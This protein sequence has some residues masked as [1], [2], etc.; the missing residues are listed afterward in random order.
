MRKA[1]KLFSIFL[2]LAVLVCYTPISAFAAPEAASETGVTETA[3]QSQFADMPNDWSTASLNAAVTNGLLKGYTENGGT[4]I[5]P[6]GTLTRAELTAVV[7]RAFGATGE[8]SLSGV[9]DVP[10]NA[11]Y[12]SDIAKA[13]KMG[14]LKLDT[15][16]RPD[17]KITRQETGTILARAFKLN[18]G[19]SSALSKFSDGSEVASWAVDG[20]SAMVAAGYLTGSDSG[21]LNPTANIT[22]AEFS[23]I[24]DNMVGKYVNTAGTVTTSVGAG[25]VMVNTPGATLDGVTISGN[26][27]IGE[28]VGDGNVTLNNVTVTGDTIV[29]GGGLNSFIVK[30]NSKLGKIIVSKADGNVRVSVEGDAN[31]G[32]VY[33]NDGKDDVVIEGKIGTVEV[34]AADVPV[35]VQNAVVGTI[36]VTAANSNLDVAKTA[37]V[38]NVNVSK[39][40]DGASVAVAG[41]VNKLTTDAP[42][43]EIAVSGTVTTVQ[44]GASAT[45][46]TVDVSKDGKLSSLNSSADIK[47]S[48]EGKPGSISGSGTVTDSKGETT[49]P[50]ATGGGGGGGGGGNSGNKPVDTTISVSNVAVSSSGISLKLT[51]EQPNMSGS[52]IIPDSVDY[53]YDIIFTVTGSTGNVAATITKPG[54]FTTSITLPGIIAGKITFSDELSPSD[55]PGNYVYSVTVNGS[56]KSTLTLTAQTAAEALTAA[57]E[58]KKAGADAV[59]D[60]KTKN[61]YTAESWKTVT[62]AIAADKVEIEKLTTIDTVNGYT[63]TALSTDLILKVDADDTLVASKSN[64]NTFLQTNYA[65]KTAAEDA[66][67]A[68]ATNG[69][70]GDN[71]I[72][73]GTGAS[74]MTAT[75]TKN[76]GTTIKFE[77]TSI[78]E[79]L[80]ADITAAKETVEGVTFNPVA[81][82]DVNTSTLA[83][84][85]VE[86]ILTDLELNDVTYSVSEKSFV[87]AIAG[88]SGATSGTNGSYK[89]AVGLT[90]GG[91]TEQTT[92]ELTLVI[93][94]TPYSMTPT[95]GTLEVTAEDSIGDSDS[96]VINVTE[97]L[98]SL[99]TRLYKNFGSMQATLPAYDNIIQADNNGWLAFPSGGKIAANNND[100]IVVVDTATA[101]GKAK[102]VGQTKALVVAYTP[103]T[104]AVLKSEE[105]TNFD[106]AST[107]ATAATGTITF[108]TPS[109]G[110]A[111][112]KAFIKGTAFADIDAVNDALGD[113]R[114]ANKQLTIIIGETEYTLTLDANYTDSGLAD[115][116]AY[117]ALI[118]TAKGKEDNPLTSVATITAG[119]NDA[120]KIE[121]NDEGAK[122]IDVT[123][124]GNILGGNAIATAGENA[125]TATTFTVSDGESGSHTFTY[126]HGT[127]SGNSITN[128]EELATAINVLDFVSATNDNGTITV[129]AETLGTAGNAYTLAVSGEGTGC[130]VSEPTLTGGKDTSDTPN[131]TFTINDIEIK[132]SKDLADINELVGVILTA[133][134]D[135]NPAI[136]AEAEGNTVVLKTDETGLSAEINI[137]GT[138][139]GEFF[140]QTSATGTDEAN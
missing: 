123:D 89:F 46:T 24:M 76:N 109:A 139:A 112:T 52:I 30:G 111:A 73:W 90:K 137:T 120:P 34:A 14:T 80:N 21:K 86:T 54:G 39:A 45:G 56:V 81:Q 100:N 6:S 9:T 127:A 26:L 15:V 71:T 22:R 108:G 57:K 132:L 129:T 23:K 130:E 116:D 118:G 2:A 47:T 102:F 49:K 94:A 65:K 82:A 98:A 93:T 74:A 83:K 68:L 106:F 36:N 117:K 16:M 5:K 55:D 10:S 70:Y 69:T 67:R 27:I 131:K 4:Y 7:N 32:L 41:T 37:K 121:L 18:A 29:K 33:I 53:E 124:S 25:N 42:K 63:L 60:G 50:P 126:I 128:A 8:A 136:T 88:I 97:G 107:P 13:V 113:C 99:D 84:A 103:A 101:D 35:K 19:N 38:E 114:L 64:D 87:A 135:A 104:K 1:R 43:T 133:L 85:A 66:I 92:D 28:G 96:T 62:D 79:Q 20:V 40:A 122:T 138:N 12:A 51:G 11:W 134:T 31:V 75:V 78:I 125:K 119:D 48:G 95:I 77:F 115:W 17:A 91:G 72:A 59:I 3:S 61:D 44:A 105:I 58:A 110:S 140:S